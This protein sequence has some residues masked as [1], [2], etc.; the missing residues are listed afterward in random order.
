MNRL[1]LALSDSS[2]KRFCYSNKSLY[3]KEDLCIFGLRVYVSLSDN[4][5]GN[6]PYNPLYWNAVGEIKDP[7]IDKSL[8]D[9]KLLVQNSLDKMNYFV[10]K[11]INGLKYIKVK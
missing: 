7:T 3:N 5:I 10:V 6:P 1:F 8:P 4:N 9:G 2:Y 11:S